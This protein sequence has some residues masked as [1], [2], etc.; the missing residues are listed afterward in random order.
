[1]N[2]EFRK[3]RLQDQWHRLNGDKPMPASALTLLSW[4]CVHDFK[5]VGHCTA[6]MA[7]GEIIGLLVDHSYR[8]PC[9]PTL[10]AHQFY[11]ALGWRPTG[12]RLANGDEILE[13][14]EGRA[15]K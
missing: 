12:E 5:V 6:D 14:P 3:A 9:D 4:E 11:R 2:L 1:M 13:T 8:R 15:P 10:P 7:T